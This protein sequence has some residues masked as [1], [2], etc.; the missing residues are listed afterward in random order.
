[1]QAT[2]RS[3]CHC[4]EKSGWLFH[5][6]TPGVGTGR[7]R[8]VGGVALQEVQDP[9]QPGCFFEGQPALQQEEV[10][11]HA[12]GHVTMPALPAAASQRAGV[13]RRGAW[14]RKTRIGSAPG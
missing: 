4:N 3:N 13:R 9:R 10:Q 8:I 11:E 2:T 6:A 1:M 14:Q 12:Q 5:Q 7:G